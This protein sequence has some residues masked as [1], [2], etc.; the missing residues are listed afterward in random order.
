MDHL[1]ETRVSEAQLG[2]W[3][4]REDNQELV[5]GGLQ[6]IHTYRWGS[7]ALLTTKQLATSYPS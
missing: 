6:Q 3:L 7:L 2:L 4:G 1:Q 5:R